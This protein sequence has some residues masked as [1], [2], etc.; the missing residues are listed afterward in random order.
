MDQFLT[1]R[2]FVEVVKK[3][4]YTEAAKTLGTSRALVSR[5]VLDLEERLGL[6]LLNRTTRSITLTTGGQ[7][8]YEFCDRILTDIRDN[9]E[10]IAGRNNEPGGS[11]SVVAPKWIGN[12]EVAD[13]ATSFSLEHPAINLKLSLGGMAPNAYDFIDQGY[14][15]AL[16]TRPIPDSLIRAKRIATIEFVLC[17]SPAFLETAPPITSIADLAE[18]RGLIHSNDPSWRLHVGD[19]VVKVRVANA[20]SSNTYLVL[21]K[22]ALKGLGLAILPRVTVQKDLESGALVQLLAD[23]PVELRY[24][25]A[26]F[27]PGKSTP[28]NVRIF[29]DYLTSWFKQHPM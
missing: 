21:R 22:A 18:Q 13:A 28:I 24:L 12:F 8:Y 17:C 16:H 29:I 10:T 14:D 26:A 23:H 4:S 25:F 19:E 5:H 15:V 1:M 9:E 27:A 11:L 6:R 7:Q 2:S 20:F 3:G